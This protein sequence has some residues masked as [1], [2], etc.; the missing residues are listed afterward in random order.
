MASPT[1]RAQPGDG[2]GPGASG[3][4]G[5][6]AFR[7]TVIGRRWSRRWRSVRGAG[8]LRLLG[9]VAAG[10]ALYLATAPRTWWWSAILGLMLLGAVLH[11]RRLRVA[12][13]LSLLAGATYYIPLLS[14][15]GVYV[16]ALPWLA[17][18]VAEALLVIPAG[19]L[20]AAATRRLPAWPVFAA[21]AWVLGE[22]LRARFPFGGFPWGGIAF[23]QPDGPLLPAA[24]LLG[25]AGLAF[26]TAL[27]GFAAADLAR[28]LVAGRT[29]VRRWAT[30]AVVLALPFG[31]G[32]AGLVTEQNTATD[33]Q[34]TVAVIQG[35]VPR[36]GLDFNAQ[37][38]AVLDNHAARTHELAAEVR[39]GTAPAPSLVI[40]PENSSDI[41]PYRNP[42]AAAVISDAA[43]DIGVPIL[44]GAVVGT[45]DPTRNLNQ[46]IV[47]D[48][49]TGPGQ[50]YTK[51]HPVPFAEYMPFRSFFRVFSDKVD[52][53][54]GEFLPGSAPGNLDIAGVAVGDVIC[55]EIVEDG[56]VRDVVDG[57]A[58][59]L[60]VQTNNATFGY[61]DETYQQQAM[62]RVRAVEHGRDVLI[63]ATSGV[64]AV[65]RSDGHVEATIGLFTPGYLTPSIG[66]NSDRTPGTVLGGPV[67]WL[68][69]ALTPLALA[70]VLVRHRTRTPRGSDARFRTQEGVF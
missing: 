33:P 20:I 64:S 69:T 19:M 26:L 40:W 68:L 53:L 62:S 44:V 13:G 4:P 35:N 32:V 12:A 67:E 55:F 36:A 27:A 2:A 1:L 42:D 5:T 34:R 29:D 28:R 58:Q 43:A 14:W 6:P 45:D 57:G 3:D 48:P 23:T 24:S 31:I 39:A 52:L 56:L 21:A 66:L 59:L 8:G 18:A 41:D 70:L 9:A 16:G 46:G 25:S 47:W 30:A 38:R 49:A 65:I 7:D 10:G 11:G 22:A 17:L 63:A 54:R 15:S 51:R 37:R 61:T 60:V 50:T